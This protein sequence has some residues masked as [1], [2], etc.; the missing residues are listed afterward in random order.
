MAERVRVRGWTD[1]RLGG[2]LDDNLDG[3]LA[4]L[5]AE[6]TDGWVRVAGLMVEWIRVCG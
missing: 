2:D 1:G 3:W 5:M 4:R 6:R